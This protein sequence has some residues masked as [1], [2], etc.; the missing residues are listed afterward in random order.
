LFR[1]KNQNRTKSSISL[2]KLYDGDTK[3]YPQGSMILFIPLTE[4][5]HYSPEYRTK[6]LFNQ[7]KFNGE[8]AAVCIG[9]LQNL[10]TVIKL[11]ND[12]KVTLQ[13]LLKGF[14]TT[15]RMSRSFLFQHIEPNATGVVAMAVYQKA[16]QAYIEKRKLTL[17]TEIRQVIANGEDTKVFQD[18]KEGMW[19]GSVFKNKG[20]KVLSSQ[21]PTRAGM[22]YADKVNKLLASPPK[23]RS[24]FSKVTTPAPVQNQNNPQ[25]TT[26]ID[27]TN[28]LPS[29]QLP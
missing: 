25:A 16:D 22:A 19:F 2:K 15:P 26:A 27:R 28:T 10:K 24:N 12:S 17:E 14:P 13:S 11:K 6:I 23:K 7:D 9:A 3:E 29:L 21:P 8:E 18:S 20:G 4:S 1:P 5:T